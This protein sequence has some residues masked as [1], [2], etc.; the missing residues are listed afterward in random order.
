MLVLENLAR[1][2]TGTGENQWAVVVSTLV[3]AALFVPLRSRL[4]DIID[5]RF[6]RQKYDAAQTIAAVGL[7]L[8]EEVDID[9]LTNDLLQAVEIT[10]QPAQ[11]AL[12]LPPPADPAA[13]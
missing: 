6:Y 8:R 11:L 7:T 5:R 13:N 4:Q 2:L 10:M 9:R 3:I 1:A 12:W